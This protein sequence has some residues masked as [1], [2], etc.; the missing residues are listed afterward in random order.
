MKILLLEAF[1]TGSHAQWAE[2]Y[3]SFSRHEVFVLSLSGHFWKW[4]MHGGA[5]SLAKRFMA[6]SFEPDLILATD[7]LD[8]SIFL[9]ATRK[10]TAHIPTVLYFHENQLTYPW[11]PT[12]ADPQLKRDRHYGFIN[13]SSAMAADAVCFNSHYHREAFLAE[14]PVFLKAFPDHQELSNV[15]II[16]E[17]SHVLPL[18]LNLAAFDAYSPPI[19][20]HK[21]NP[22]LIL[23]NHRWEYDKGP[24]LFF[25]TLF[26]L[27]AEALSFELVVLGQGY[28]KH[29]AI[30]HEAQKRLS[31]VIVHWGYEDDFA[32]YAQWLWR[33]DVMPV[34]SVHDFFGVSV[35]QALYCNTYPLLPRSLAYPEHI[36]QKYH[37]A[38]FYEDEAALFAKLREFIQTY[39]DKANMPTQGFVE[40]YDWRGL[41]A[42]YDGYFEG[43]SA[44]DD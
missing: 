20:Q 6:S 39:P 3:Q 14:L 5:I 31:S 40:Q 16:Q 10:R 29:P 18:G 25:N 1:F 30:F 2:E 11:S 37:E 4:R 23:W 15:A 12:D 36:P 43:L 35:V 44:G 34:T 9:A 27:Q 41:V 38:F 22:P 26:Q 42:A 7:M 21:N 8:L 24:E 33:A 17:K 28:K 19:K 13:Y 32:K